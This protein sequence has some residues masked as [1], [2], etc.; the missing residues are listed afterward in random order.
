M[1]EP[2]QLFFR[3][4]ELAATMRQFGFHEIEDLSSDDLNTRYPAGRRADRLKLRGGIGRLMREP[5]DFVFK[6]ANCN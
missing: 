6:S 3:P 5:V 2:F 4:V 1:G